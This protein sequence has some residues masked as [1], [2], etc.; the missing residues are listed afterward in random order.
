[1]RYKI[2]DIPGEGRVENQALPKS[3]LKE[4]LEGE[5]AD[6]ERSSGEVHL[7]LVK[8]HEDVVVR[9]RLRGR[10]VVPCGLCLRPATVD[11]DTPIHVTF[12]PEGTSD[13]QPQD[14]LDE[15]DSATHD[16]LTVDLEPT[17][18]EL[19]ILSVPMTPRC[20]ASCRGLCPVCGANQNVPEERDCGHDRHDVAVDPRL[21]AL[22]SVKLS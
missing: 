11:I 22:K 5:S 16:G 4:A 14:L 19:L 10:A 12:A 15:A 6:L 3:L 7:E 2:K 17:V 8:A 18:R 21:A 9:G 1:L 13:E 20:S